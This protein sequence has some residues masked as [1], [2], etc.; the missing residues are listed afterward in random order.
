MVNPRHKKDYYDNT[1]ASKP[2][3]FIIGFTIAI[4]LNIVIW[5]FVN[6]IYSIIFQISPFVLNFVITFFIDLILSSIIL[7]LIYN[8]NFKGRELVKKG[9]ILAITLFIL[10]PLV[11]LGACSILLS[12]M[13]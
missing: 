1:N 6:S 5:F 9:M 13:G 2:I 4:V 3:D 12:G 10:I 11:V 7:I 8:K